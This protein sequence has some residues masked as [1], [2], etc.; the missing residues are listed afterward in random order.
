MAK[1]QSVYSLWTLSVH[2][3]NAIRKAIF[4]S[5]PQVARLQMLTRAQ[6]GRVNSL[7][8]LSVCPKL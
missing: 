2:Q 7:T 5:G 6:S 4:A 8:I 3:R 1:P